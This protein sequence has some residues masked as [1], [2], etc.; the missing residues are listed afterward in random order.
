MSPFSVTDE[1]LKKHLNVLYTVLEP[2]VIADE[3]FQA[4]Q[5]SVND[6]DYLT[7]DPKKYRRMMN[8]LDVLKQKQLYAH[9]LCILEFLQYTSVLATLITDIQ[10][11]NVACK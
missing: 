2:R 8:L 4:G 10:L 7:N 6:H 3:M 5:I 11:T 9:F 1:L